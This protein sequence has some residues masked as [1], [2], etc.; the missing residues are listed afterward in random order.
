MRAPTTNNTKLSMSYQHSDIELRCLID[1]SIVFVHGLFGHP[2]KTWESE[3]TESTEGKS[4]SKTDV[5]TKVFWPNDFLV[6]DLAQAR[7]WT[8]G[9]N[10]DLIREM[11]DAHGKTSISQYGEKLVSRIALDIENEVL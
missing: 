2:K 10:A 3:L 6:E 5:K 8:Y 9:Y 11:F 4:Y 1:G 7:I